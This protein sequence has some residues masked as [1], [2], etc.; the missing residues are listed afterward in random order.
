MRPSTKHPEGDPPEYRVERVR[1][2]LATDPR[3][4][5]LELDIVVRGDRVI[6]GGTVLTR[7][8]HEAIPLA[9]AEELPDVQV[10]NRTEIVSK[11]EPEDA[12]RLP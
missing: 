12:E 8:Q 5:E 10:E 6:I 3:V 2:A 4:G 9:L 11:E 7:Q 1:H